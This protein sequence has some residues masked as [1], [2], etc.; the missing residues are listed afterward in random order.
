MKKKQIDVILSDYDGTLCSTPSVRNGI[1]PIGTIPQD[2]EQILFHISERI[3]ICIISSKDFEFLHCRA[4]FARILSCVLGTE[5]V[6]HE[7]H[8]RD[9]TENYDCIRCQVLITNILT[10]LSHEL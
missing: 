2:L 5:T 3:P 10:R 7:P 1:G 6:I 8:Y 9:E 4:R